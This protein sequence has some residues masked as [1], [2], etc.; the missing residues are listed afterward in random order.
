MKS[1]EV[2][3]LEDLKA[4]LKANENLKFN[5]SCMRNADD[6]T[7]RI[8]AYSEK[9]NDEAMLVF[10]PDES[11]ANINMHIDSQKFMDAYDS[12]GEDEKIP[13]QHEI[14]N[15][16][17]HKS[18]MCDLVEVASE[19]VLALLGDFNGKESDYYSLAKLAVKTRPR[20]FSK[21]NGK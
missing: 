14:T 13:S 11:Y 15:P 10:K 18:Y 21:W 4:F 6:Y 3:N 17:R 8:E 19:Q 12:L 1:F 7:L 2:K 9:P 16:C 20:I 5:Y